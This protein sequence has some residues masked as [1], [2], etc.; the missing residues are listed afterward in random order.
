[1]SEEGGPGRRAVR[2][3]AFLALWLGVGFPAGTAVLLGPLRWTADALRAAGAPAGVEAWAARGVMLLLAAASFA[4]ARWLFR[5]IRRSSSLLDRFVAP[6]AVVLLAAASL[7]LWLSPGL[8]SSEAL[9][10]LR[11]EA[12]FVLGPYPDAD[13]LR[14]LEEGGYTAVVSLLHPAVVPFEP[15]LLEREREAAR[16]AGV[17]LVHVPLLP[18]VGENEASLERLR[19]LARDEGG[20]YYVH[21]YLGRD[22]VRLAARAARD[23][24]ARVRYAAETTPARRLADTLRLERGGV[25]E[26]ADRIFV[27]PYPTREEYAGVVLAGRV[28]SVVSLLDP[29]LPDDTAW[30][31]R[32]RR[33]VQPYAVRYREMPMPRHPDAGWA[34]T[35]ADSVRRLPRPVYVH[36]F[37]APSGRTEALVEAFGTIAGSGGAADE[38]GG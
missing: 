4:A 33:R 28:R 34:W 16:R 14:R 36:G 9:L 30:I 37:R 7:G 23:V 10:P 20:H 32:E 31:H 21:C 29:S 25:T 5:R 3:A 6:G 27:G 18:W 35:V 24:G 2:V 22:R 26:V 17:R 13:D 1:M 15:R 12:R 38:G 19:E 11:P 8:L